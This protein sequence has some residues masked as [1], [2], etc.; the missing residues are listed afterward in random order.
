LIFPD[1]YGGAN[2]T[3]MELTILFEAMGRYLAPVPFLPT[4]VL[5]GLTVLYGGTEEQ[6]KKFLPRIAEGELV[7][8]LG[9]TEANAGYDISRTT[10]RAVRKEKSFL[11]NGTKTFVPFAGA[12]DYVI[13]IARVEEGDGK[14]C[15][16]A[17]VVVKGGGGGVDY[18]PLETLASDHQYEI[19]FRNVEIPEDS[20][21]LERGTDGLIMVNKVLECAT[22]A[23]CALMVGGA[24]KALQMAVDYAKKRTQFGHHIGSFQAMQHRIANS[25]I[26]LDGAKFAT[27][28][29]VWK[30]DQGVPCGQ[31]VSIAKAW[32]NQACQRICANAHQ[33]FGG[34][35]VIIDHDIQ[36]YSRR[37]KMGE[38]LWGDTTFHREIVADYLEKN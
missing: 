3:F 13:C 18:T 31:D 12:A 27:Y 8:T 29:A 36:L 37:V 6:K 2:G 11:L 23:Q 10:A 16:I 19:V 15:R 32:V 33:V 14:E 24:E 4:V 35:G 1:K 7:F 38:Y 20:I 28:R 34:V 21:L 9:A 30:L 22:I 17:P 5:G 26:D 25:M